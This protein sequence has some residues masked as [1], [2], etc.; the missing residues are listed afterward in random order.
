MGIIDPKKLFKKLFASLR[1]Y[2]KGYYF[3]HAAYGVA[4]ASIGFGMATLERIVRLFPPAKC[5]L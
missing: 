3:S 2:I 1:N 4:T 5:L